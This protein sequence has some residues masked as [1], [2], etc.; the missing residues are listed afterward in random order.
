MQHSSALT[1]NSGQYFVSLYFPCCTGENVHS[2]HGKHKA[3]VMSYAN[4]LSQRQQAPLD[5]KYYRSS[6][7]TKLC[8]SL[9]LHLKSKGSELK[10][11]FIQIIGFN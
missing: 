6:W 11:Q 2:K 7:M 4:F 8:T 5:T 3:M 10:V 1:L 9:P